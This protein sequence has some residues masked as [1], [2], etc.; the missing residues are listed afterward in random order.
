MNVSDRFKAAIEAVVIRITGKYDYAGCY[1]YT[2]ASQNADGTLELKPDLPKKVPGLSN[3]SIS[4]GNPGETAKVSQGARCYVIFPNQD[5]ANPRV[6]GWENGGLQSIK[7]GGGT[8]PAAGIGATVN[9]F[10]PPTVPVS[11]TVSGNPFVG[12]ITITTPGIGI[13][14][15]GNP[16]V[17]V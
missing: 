9:V 15:T 3:V 10:F 16:G 12:V 5:P 17:L 11:G 1:S 14:Q 8:A 6:L 4:Y 13:V 2:V 7:L